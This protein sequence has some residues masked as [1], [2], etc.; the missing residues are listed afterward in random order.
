[1]RIL[2]VFAHPDK[3]SLNGALLEDAV[4]H[5][6]ANGHEVKITDLYEDTF[7]SV[8]DGDDA[9]DRIEEGKFRAFFDRELSARNGHIPE[10]IK[11]EQEKVF[12]ADLL[13]FQYPLWW[14]GMPAIMKGWMDRVLMSGF[15]FS[16]NP[17]GKGGPLLSGKKAMMLVTAG[18][19]RDKFVDGGQ[20]G[21]IQQ[22][23]F[24]IKKTFE[25]CGI[26][27]IDDHV[28]Y[29]TISRSPQNY[30]SIVKEMK[31]ALDKLEI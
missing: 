19:K 13:L 12:W 31:E 2:F 24:P 3:Q 18:A 5:L 26:E 22:N 23:F 21:D 7:K 10:D 25:C 15:A 6:K 4:S 1:M 16:N 27:P 14:F 20:F 29:G 17:N 11:R 8:L 9:P 28:V 30:V